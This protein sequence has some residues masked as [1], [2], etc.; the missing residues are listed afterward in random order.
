MEASRFISRRF[1]VT[2]LIQFLPFFMFE[3]NPSYVKTEQIIKYEYLK[4]KI[5]FIHMG[6]VVKKNNIIKKPEH[7]TIP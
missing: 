3:A 6:I 4:F 7:Y 5:I 1:A 2:F